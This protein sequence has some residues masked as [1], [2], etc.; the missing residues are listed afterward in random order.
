ML[1]SLEGRHGVSAGERGVPAKLGKGGG[2]D[3]AAALLL[4]ALYSVINLVTRA[5][6]LTRMSR[7]SRSCRMKW[8]SL[9]AASPNAQS[10]ML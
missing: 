7:P 8:R 10:L 1:I 3:H 5:C 9:S 6:V 2:G 4:G